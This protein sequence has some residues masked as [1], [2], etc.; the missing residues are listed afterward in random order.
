MGG[1]RFLYDLPHESLADDAEL[2]AMVTNTGS[3]D[4]D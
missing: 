4:T 3:T 2:T 1:R